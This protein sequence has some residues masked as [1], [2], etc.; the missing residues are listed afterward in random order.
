MLLM[1]GPLCLR[2]IWYRNDHNTI[3]RKS[4]TILA[5]FMTNMEWSRGHSNCLADPSGIRIL[6]WAQ[7]FRLFYRELLV[8]IEVWCE[9]IDM[10]RLF[11]QVEYEIGWNKPDINRLPWR[12]EFGDAVEESTSTI[13][14][15]T[16][17]ST[18]I[19][20]RLILMMTIW[21]HDSRQVS[22]PTEWCV[23]TPTDFFRLNIFEIDCALV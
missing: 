19:L 21:W 16:K 6:N 1:K 11:A 7:T 9:M 20:L 3:C 14:C 18:L 2:N 17:M 12:D 10:T 5:V 22:R 13:V 4:P 15:S 8:M 23:I